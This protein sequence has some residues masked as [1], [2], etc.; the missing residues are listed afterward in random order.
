MESHL[1]KQCLQ[2]NEK[3]SI[4]IVKNSG[5][6]SNTLI[7]FT[8]SGQNPKSIGEIQEQ[9]RSIE[10]NNPKNVILPDSVSETNLEISFLYKQE[11]Q[12][13]LMNYACQALQD[14]TNALHIE[15]GY[16]SKPSGTGI[17]TD[18]FEQISKP[19]F[20]T[21]GSMGLGLSISEEIIKQHNG[22]LKF[23]Q[24][25]NSSTTVVISLPIT[26]KEILTL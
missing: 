12:Q 1:K 22:T 19:F 9:F 4:W 24:N 17:M 15:S 20:S 5:G 18:H 25:D 13:V 7:N 23:I 6:E 3:C 21:K 2:Q 8:K 14:P 26:K 16:N 10:K 11:L